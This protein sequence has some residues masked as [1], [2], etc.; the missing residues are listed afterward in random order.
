MFSQL[1]AA[2]VKHTLPPGS[3]A[4]P[5]P[6]DVAPALVVDAPATPPVL[7]FPALLPPLPALLPPLPALPALPAVPIGGFESPA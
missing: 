3:G 7:T 5:A 2:Q 4:P 6:A 1:L